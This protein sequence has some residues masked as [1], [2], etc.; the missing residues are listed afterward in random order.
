[1]LDFSHRCDRDKGGAWRL[2]PSRG[3]AKCGNVPFS[4][5]AF[6]IPS[7]LLCEEGLQREAQEAAQGN[8][9]RPSPRYLNMDSCVALSQ[10]H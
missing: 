3:A 7:A 2:E 9:R 6:G 10:T 5:G 1:M 8:A 4:D